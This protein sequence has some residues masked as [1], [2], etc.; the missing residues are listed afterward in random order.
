M[1]TWERQFRTITGNVHDGGYTSTKTGSHVNLCATCILVKNDTFR[2][3]RFR[4][5][6][7]ESQPRGSI[8]WLADSATPGV[9]SPIMLSQVCLHLRQAFLHVSGNKLSHNLRAFECRPRLAV[10]TV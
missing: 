9:D 5:R 2:M 4:A 3:G 1:I 6:V 8:Q 7:I 10:M